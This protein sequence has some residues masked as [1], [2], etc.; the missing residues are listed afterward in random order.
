MKQITI[1]LFEP[2]PPNDYYHISIHAEGSN[3]IEIPTHKYG[4]EELKNKYEIKDTQQ[5][6][7]HIK[8]T[9]KPIE[10]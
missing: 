3:S 5:R 4:A 2:I 7:N 8:T 9:F 1:E 10:L 6:R